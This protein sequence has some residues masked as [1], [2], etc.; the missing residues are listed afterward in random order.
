MNDAKGSCTRRGWLALSGLAA[1]VCAA[2]RAQTAP[3]RVA[4]SAPVSVAKVRSYDEDL[5]TQFRTM[6]DQIGGIGGQV[7][8]KTVAIKVNLTGGTRFD[9]YEPGETHWVHPK[10]VGAVTAVLGGLGAKRIRILESAAGGGR[11]TSWKTSCC[12]AAG[13]SAR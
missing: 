4:P 7:R 8:G 9:G 10:V 6:F 11:T 13:T 3:Q 2:A 5:V 12:K 1:G